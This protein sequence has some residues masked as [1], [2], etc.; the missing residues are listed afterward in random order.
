[1]MITTTSPMFRSL[2]SGPNQRKKS[3]S[4][5]WTPI[6]PV[7]TLPSY[8]E[9]GLF[10]ALYPLIVELGL[11]RLERMDLTEVTERLESKDS[12]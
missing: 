11:E 10:D 5:F 7:R 3:F 4:Q 8:P 12:G 1:M 2:G 9:N 6:F